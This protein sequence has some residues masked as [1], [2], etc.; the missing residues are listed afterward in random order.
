M[1]WAQR[2][3]QN[4]S[5]TFWFMDLR[6]SINF[7]RFGC[8]FC[9]SPKR[10]FYQKVAFWVESNAI[11]LQ[12]FLICAF[13]ALR[14]ANKCTLTFF[15]S[16]AYFWSIDLVF[17]KWYLQVD[18]SKQIQHKFLTWRSNPTV[19]NSSCTH[20]LHKIMNA[21]HKIEW[22]LQQNMTKKEKEEH[23]ILLILNFIY[24]ACI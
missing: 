22:L 7:A 21:K 18:Y 16:N 8:Y 20:I 19:F 23:G 14:S 6:R 24:L 9:L 17:F 3:Y 13:S 10:S 11:F 12:L 15:V 1:L 4:A 2:I 5:F